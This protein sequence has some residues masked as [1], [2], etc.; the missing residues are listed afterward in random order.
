MKSS[1]LRH[2]LG[3]CMSSV[4]TRQR[5]NKDNSAYLDRAQNTGSHEILV[6]TSMPLQHQKQVEPWYCRLC[7]ASK[8][9]SSIC[10]RTLVTR[11]TRLLQDE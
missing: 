2:M 5:G 3:H 11:L 6:C 1:A 4:S 7:D 10:K 8:L 9:T